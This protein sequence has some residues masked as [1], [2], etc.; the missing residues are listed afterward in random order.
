MSLKEGLIVLSKAVH[1]L[2]V[3][4]TIYTSNTYVRN[5]GFIHRHRLRFAKKWT[6]GSEGLRTIT[7][8]Q[9]TTSLLDITTEGR[10]SYP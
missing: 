3:L 1:T 8:S 4:E 9:D 2:D 6:V 5:S 10:A 7:N